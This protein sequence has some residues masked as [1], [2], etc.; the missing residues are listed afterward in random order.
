N[1]IKQQ[2]K[3]IIVIIKLTLLQFILSIIITQLVYNLEVETISRILINL[4][5]KLLL[6]CFKHIILQPLI[7]GNFILSHFWYKRNIFN[8]IKI[9]F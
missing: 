9:I 3:G 7:V 5:N 1:R 2:K 6:D 4:I 8:S